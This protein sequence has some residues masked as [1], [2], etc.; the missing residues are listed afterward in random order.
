MLEWFDQIFRGGYQHTLQG[1]WPRV[2]GPM[3]ATQPLNPPILSA[4][5]F[6]TA[7][8]PRWT[9]GDSNSYLTQSHGCALPFELV[10]PKMVAGMVP[11]PQE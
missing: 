1:F 11:I 8:S 4:A 5:H 9:T 10:V 3:P 6:T 2:V 7:T